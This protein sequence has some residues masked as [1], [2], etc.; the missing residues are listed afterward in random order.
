MN[1]ILI[2]VLVYFTIMAGHGLT[3][4]LFVAED[5]IDPLMQVFRHVLTLQ[6]KTHLLQEVI[7]ICI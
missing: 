3:S 4:L 1:N 2:L 5:Q 6:C 7:W